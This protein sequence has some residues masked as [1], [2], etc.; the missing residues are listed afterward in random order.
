MDGLQVFN[1]LEDDFIVQVCVANCCFP[2]GIPRAETP[3]LEKGISL[4]RPW[5]RTVVSVKVGEYDF[6][7]SSRSSPSMWSQDP[8][9]ITVSCFV[10]VVVE[11]ASQGKR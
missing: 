3:S 9:V 4:G 7:L 6:P 11:G 2:M 8:E 1:G 5:E 10:V